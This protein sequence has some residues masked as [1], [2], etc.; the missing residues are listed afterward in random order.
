MS[1]QMISDFDPH[2]LDIVD[3]KDKK[4]DKGARN[5]L[6]SVGKHLL[7]E[8]AHPEAGENRSGMTLGTEGWRAARW[9]ASSLRRFLE[10]CPLTEGSRPAYTLR[11]HRK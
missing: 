1:R 5:K 3:K 11:F 9:Q 6:N 7:I 8:N 10:F 4:I 2:A